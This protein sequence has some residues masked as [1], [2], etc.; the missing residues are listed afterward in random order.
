VKVNPGDHGAGFIYTPV[1][2]LGAS[3]YWLRLCARFEC[4]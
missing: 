4:A 3:D 2:S 1:H